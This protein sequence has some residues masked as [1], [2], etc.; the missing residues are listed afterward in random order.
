MDPEL[1]FLESQKEYD[2]AGDYSHVVPDQDAPAD[3]EE[4]DYDPSSLLPSYPAQDAHSLSDQSASMPESATNTPPTDSAAGRKPEPADVAATTLPL[5]KQPRTK[6]GFVDESEDEEDEVPVSRPKAAGSAFLNAS[7]VANSPQRSL[8]QTPNNTLPPSN[9]PLHSSQDQGPTGVSSSTSVAV[10]VTAP[11]LASAVPNGGTPMP[12]ATKQAIPDPL[13]TASARPSVT[14]VTP[15]VAPPPKAR[16]PQ[17]RVGILE[18]RIAEDPRGDVEAWLSLIEEHRRRH[19]I[20]DTRAVYDRFFKVFPTAAEQWAEYVNMESELE[21]FGR[22]ER[23][24]ERSIMT[25]P[26]VDLWSTY[27]NYIRRRNNVTTDQTGNARSIITQVYEFVLDNVGIDINSGKIWLDYI[28][29]IKSGPGVVGGTS[30]QDGQKVDQLRKVYQRAVSIPTTATLEIWREY[31]K[32]EMSLNKVTGRKNL[33]DNS[34][35]YMTARAAI[36]VLLEQKTKDLIRTTLPK[37]PPA[38]GYDGYKEYQQQIQEWRNWIEYE[39]SDPLMLK[40]DHPSALKKR[41]AYLYRHALMALRFFPE[42]WYEAAEWSFQNGLEKEGNDFLT[43]GIEANPE[44]CLL[45]FRKA[46]QIELSG[47]FEDGEAGILRKGEAVREPFNK[48]LDALYDLTSKTKK[49]EE[50]S[51]A[52]TKEAFAAQQAAE[53]ATRAENTS[54]DEYSDHEEEAAK[55]TQKRKEKEEALQETLRTISGA[56]NEQI[57]TL[58]KTISYTWIALM[59]TMRRIQG[60]G[61]PDAPTGT[62]PG[63]RGIFAEARKKGKLLSDAY[64]AS[65]LIEHHCYQDPA[66]TKIFDRGMRLFPD[67]EHFALEYAKYL[68]KQNDATNARAVFETIVTRLTSKPES[69]ARAKPLFLFFHEYESQFGELAQ[70]VKLEKR[71]GD[72]FPE[73][74]Q[75]T[76][77]ASRFSTSTFDPTTVQPIIS[78]KSQMRPPMPSIIPT[79]EEPPAPPPAQVQP[80]QPS[81]VLNSPRIPPALIAVSNS[82]KRP[83]DDLDNEQAQPRKL[84]RG[85]SPLKGAAGRRL[86]AARRNLARASEGVSNIAVPPPP[87]PLPREINFLLGIIPGAHT[88][89][90]TRFN[91]ERMVSLIQSVDLN[92]ANLTPN[93]QTPVNQAH[94][95]PPQMGHWGAPP[96]GAGYQMG[97]YG[98]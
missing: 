32:F 8:S 84:A 64:V 58:K 86:D 63:F 56:F 20:D 62:P 80:K 72:L 35:R 9:V 96:P 48:V 92:R 87:A 40:E 51:L 28:E 34:S 45:A 10:N 6:G 27:V 25:C 17:D 88:Y 83:F 21:E 16:L 81:P 97:Y 12:D 23:L 42:M 66:A 67:D 70:I 79:V 73:D 49:R 41:M 59:R 69:V 18:D 15:I 38:P 71:M 33:Q 95:P 89:K 57:H 52:Q 98:R 43:Q 91:A 55:L 36:A 50:F 19:K 37:L 46:H 61:R 1:A 68:V 31:D 75:L 4:E 53:E 78:Q 44:S 13:N 60:K 74:P 26:H 94:P 82:P 85:E 29:F 22:V 24:F 93:N 54:N 14:P 90:E 30:W 5:T 77:F 11:T 47:E 7:G 76:R 65:A 3:E 39:K 2:P